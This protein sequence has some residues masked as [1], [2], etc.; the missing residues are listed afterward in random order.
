ME[1]FTNAEMADMHIVYGEVHCNGRAA[2]RLYA[3]RYPNRRVPN[4]RMFAS[5]HRNLCEYGAFRR[6][7]HDAGHPRTTRSPAFEEDVLRRVEAA[8]GISTRAIARD[9]PSSQSSVWRTCQAEKLHPYHFQR[10]QSL[11]PEDFPRRLEFARWYLDQ[12]NRNSDF[13][14]SILFTDEAI[15]SRQGIFNQHN[16]HEWSHTNPRSCKPRAAQQRFSVNVWAGIIGDYLIGPYLLPSRLDGEKYRIF[17]KEVLPKLLE[18][19]P[20]SVRRAMWFQHDGAPAHYAQDVR[21]YLSNT[22]PQQWIGRRGPVR[23]PARSPDLSCLDFFFWGALKSMVYET[24][25]DTDTVLVARISV[26]AANISEKPGIFERVRQSMRRRCEACI[27]VN[28]NNFEH[29]L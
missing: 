1:E 2:C 17:L 8:P 26:A 19:V 4:Y 20:T 27:R 21:N 22:F 28:G 7:R 24:P 25:V 16:I 18:N 14:S 3:E 29:L 13:P 5:L 9:I 11:Q 15:F 6:N 12:C 10:V 23:W